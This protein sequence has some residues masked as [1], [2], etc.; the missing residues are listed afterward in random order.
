V[1]NCVGSFLHTVTAI[2]ESERLERM[3]KEHRRI[4]REK[5]RCK[6]EER[7]RRRALEAGR[8]RDLNRRLHYWKKAKS[9]RDLAAAIGG[10]AHSRGEGL[11]S[12][13]DIA[14][15]LEWARGRADR[16]ERRAVRAFR[17]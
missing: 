7:E 13:T 12:Q 14:Q 16:L 5:Q 1:E 11:H 10:D 2:A 15:W 8:V 6:E 9:I 17:L 4:E 3:A